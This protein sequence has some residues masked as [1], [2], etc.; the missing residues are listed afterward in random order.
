MCGSR[1]IRL[2]CDLEESDLDWASSVLHEADINMFAQ[3]YGWLNMAKKCV[4]SD[5]VHILRLDWMR[6]PSCAACGVT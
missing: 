3:M 4:L 1:K 5:L 2:R 6:S